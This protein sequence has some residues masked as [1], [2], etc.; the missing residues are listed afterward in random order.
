VIE[1]ETQ[2]KVFASDTIFGRSD[3]TQAAPAWDVYDEDAA[4]ATQKGVA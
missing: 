4:K 2:Q 3:S 1:P